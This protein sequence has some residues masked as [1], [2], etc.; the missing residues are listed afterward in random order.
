[1]QLLYSAVKN[2]TDFTHDVS[3]ASHSNDLK[4]VGWDVKL[5]PLST[6]LN[7][8][9]PQKTNIGLRLLSLLRHGG[10]QF[11]QNVKI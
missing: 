9:E 8:K 1:M 6:L 7:G 4:C 10:D 11:N 2:P 3:T 5:Y